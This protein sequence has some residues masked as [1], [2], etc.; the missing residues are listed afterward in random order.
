MI[1][2][3]GLTRV[4]RGG[5]P[6]VLLD[7][8]FEARPGAVTALLG[9][10]GA[11]KST[12]LRLMLE[13]ERGRGVTLFDGRT[14]R[15]LRRPEREVGVLLSGSADAP[16]ASDL[17]G[18]PGR[19]ARGHLRMLAAAVG[20]PTR[21]ADELLERTRLAAV[22]EQRLRT[23]SP[24]MH[25]R[26]ALAAALLGEPGT[27]LLDAPTE[28]L[29]PR[30]VEWFHA[31]LRSFAADGG[32]VLVTTRTPQEASQ[33][34]DRVVTLDRGRLAA[35]QSVTEFRRTR[36]SPEVAV[37]GPQM[38]RLAD[39]LAGQG[40]QVRR[41]GGTELAVS[42]VGRTEIGELAYR[43]GILL[44]EL[45]DRVVER[46]APRADLRVV[47]SGPGR[48]RTPGAAAATA[49]PTSMAPTATD[50]PV[51]EDAMAVTAVRAE[52]TGCT[53]QAEQADRTVAMPVARSRALAAAGRDPEPAPTLALPVA[54][55]PAGGSSA[56]TASA[57]PGPRRGARAVTRGTAEAA[58]AARVPAE[59]V[60]TVRTGRRS[61]GRREDETSP[62][63]AVDRLFRD[64]LT[65][66]ARSAQA[67]AAV[68][69]AEAH[70]RPGEAADGLLGDDTVRLGRVTRPQPD[71][72][73][74]PAPDRSAAPGAHPTGPDRIGANPVGANP[75]G[76]VVPAT[77]DLRSE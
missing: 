38:A 48:P 9:P 28:G 72:A 37:R 56:V 64:G 53:E 50:A 66:L 51:P 18:H 20:A 75:T 35:D 12:A 63:V 16:G 77:S 2:I 58:E 52:R 29:S 68:P 74:Q 14:Y 24:G 46:P 67:P 1:Q 8:T 33:L 59:A 13:L 36:L 23:Y 39:L 10:E 25:R 21:R 47:A 57:A 15:R 62:V 7:L 49:A 19:K 61:S 71:R 30:N 5:G 40:A 69:G 44:H 76:P 27:L 6:P 41:D 70:R 73:E 22:A 45:A 31:F 54:P 4:H 43:H 26:L 60:G 17:A 55:P 3:T 65:G 32:T 34:A 11:G 42:G